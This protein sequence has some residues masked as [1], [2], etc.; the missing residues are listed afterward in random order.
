MSY[1]VAAIASVVN[2][3]LVCW[4]Y[5]R[6]G[7]GITLS[8]LVGEALRAGTN[9]LVLI[10]AVAPLAAG[11]L[12]FI[13]LFYAV[14][15][16][17]VA[18][19]GALLSIRAFPAAPRTARVPVV[20]LAASNLVLFLVGR[21]LAPERWYPVELERVCPLWLLIALLIAE[22]VLVAM[23]THVLT[24]RLAGVAATRASRDG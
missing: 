2:L 8:S 7:L 5:P 4:L 1:V 23:L 6:L 19:L 10:F 9:G 12:F 15:A 18:P 3:S 24:R 22:A 13:G 20:L 11:V 16:L 17:V 21:K 14:P